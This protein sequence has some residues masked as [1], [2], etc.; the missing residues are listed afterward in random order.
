MATPEMTRRSKL[1]VGSPSTCRST[2][3]PVIWVKSPVTDKVPVRSLPPPSG[4]MVPALVSVPP[5]MSK[6]PLPVSS[7]LL[8]KPPGLTTVA[9]DAV[10]IVP[11]CDR[12]PP[13]CKLPACTS[14][15]P[16]LVSAWLMVKLPEPDFVS[17]PSIPI[18]PLPAK[19]PDDTSSVPVTCKPAPMSTVP[20]ATSSDAP[21]A[22]TFAT[23]VGN[24]R[25]P[26]WIDQVPPVMVCAAPSAMVNAPPVRVSVGSVGG[27]ANVADPADITRDGALLA[28]RKL[29][30]APVIDSGMLEDSG[31]LKVTLPVSNTALPLPPTVTVPP[32]K[33]EPAANT[34]LPAGAVKF[35]DGPLC[36]VT[37]KSPLVLVMASETTG[38][39][40]MSLSSVVP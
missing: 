32:L 33:V 9:E 15:I 10:W 36:D 38:L 25:L 12:L 13:S 30:S 4:R 39:N 27:A 19:L 26:P 11:V 7:P 3:P 8:V 29:T 6:V 1:A 35:S 37:S 22:I 23:S 20:P 28:A 2:T 18:G 17:W 24:C 34:T 40:T 21:L 5:P 14:I 16:V 31:L